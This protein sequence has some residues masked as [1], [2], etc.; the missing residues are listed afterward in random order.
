MATLSIAQISEYNEAVLALKKAKKLELELRNKIIHTY[1]FNEFEGVQHRSMS[2]DGVD[3]E[4]SV[5][6]K[7]NRI[8]D[9]KLLEEHWSSL[10]SEER[11]VF[12]YT[13]KLNLKK[14]REMVDSGDVK[15][16][17]QFVTEKP[18]QAGL[19]VS[20]TEFLSK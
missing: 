4:I 8:I 12:D 14:Y 15:N 18:A 20:L 1:R 11:D 9:N 7:L 6:L 2:E 19:K 16:L 5:T 3:A 17:S 13:P 10:T